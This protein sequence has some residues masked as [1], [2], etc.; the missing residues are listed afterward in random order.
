MPISGSPAENGLHRRVT[1]AFGGTFAI[2][3]ADRAA[4]ILITA[5]L[6]RTLTPAD[7]GVVAAA[8]VFVSFLTMVSQMGIGAALIQAPQLTQRTVSAAMVS[9][10]ATAVVALVAAMAAAPL[11]GQWFRNPDVVGVVRVLGLNCIIQALTVIPNALMMRGLRGRTISSIEMA[12]A[13]IGTGAVAVPMAFMGWGYWSLAVGV[14]AQTVVRTV[15][16]WMLARPNTSLEFDLAD[17]TRLW[18]RGSG[19]LL[20]NILNKL[21]AEGDRWVVGRYLTPTGLGLYSK[22]SGLMSFPSRLYGTALDRVAFPAFAKVQNEKDRMRR[23]YADALSLTAVVGLPLTVLL[24][25][26]GPQA[27]LLV[28]GSQWVGMIGPF[29]ILSLA[30]YFRL[31]DKTNA[32]LLRGAGR[33]FL[34]SGGQACYGAM[35]FFGGLWAVR[36][37]IEAVAWVVAAAAL[38]ANVLL[39]VLAMR[40]ARLSLWSLPLAHAPGVAA[41]ILTAVALTPAGWAAEHYALAP[42]PALALAGLCLGAAALAAIVLAPRIFLGRS[43]MRV[44]AV[45]FPWL[46]RAHG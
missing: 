1:F 19:Y 31:A 25:F 13:A 21:S 8:T 14:L 20:N 41:A 40:T 36:H 28:L 12:A 45:V 2:V 15:L 17:M 42:F 7:F 11:I 37:G 9:V 43:G 6:A 22:A 33:P 38:V 34:I 35:V 24:V 29:K 39:T 16:L 3:V 4:Q 27:I 10:L 18:R 46:A 23:A 44:L 26:T 30:I 32:A 5:V